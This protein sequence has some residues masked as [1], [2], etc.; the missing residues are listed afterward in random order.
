MTTL[1]M[2]LL[3][4][5]PEFICHYRLQTGKESRRTQEN[6]QSSSYKAIKEMID[7]VDQSLA[8]IEMD[9]ANST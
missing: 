3:D 8:N 5:Q 9:T 4:S 7:W 1:W 6:S 2:I